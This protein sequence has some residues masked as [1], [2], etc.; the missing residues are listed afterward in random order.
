MSA[1]ISVLLKDFASS[2]L[3]W[4][5][6]FLSLL[7][8]FLKDLPQI[9]E[10]K[11]RVL[12]PISKWWLL[13]KFQREAVRSCIQGRVNIVVNSLE[14][15][16]PAGSI[17]PL[18]IIYVNS[19]QREAFIREGKVFVRIRPVEDQDRNFINVIQLYLGQVLLPNSRKLLSEEQEKSVIYLTAYKLLKT[20]GTVAEK[21]HDDYYL[22]DVKRSGKIKVYFEKGREVDERGL[23]FSVVLRIVEEGAK[24]MRFERGDL[25]KEFDCVLEHIC[26]FVKELKKIGGEKDNDF[27]RYGGD[28]VSFSLLLVAD[29]LKAMIGET[30]VYLKRFED[31]LK[32]TRYVFVLFSKTEW[33][34]FGGRV[35]AAIDSFE[36]AKLVGVIRSAYDYRGKE[37]GIV[38]IYTRKD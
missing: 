28:G 29:P 1:E 5:L 38:R 34:P 27:W 18:E 10:L 19:S 17:K 25:K 15:E 2:Y 7:Y 3:G 33:W 31:N 11:G 36:Q 14:G 24:A 30:D 32:I 21:L 23:F 8:G 12:I 16:M 6:F 22:P 13:R 20:R 37:D 26:N 9:L 4:V 35:A